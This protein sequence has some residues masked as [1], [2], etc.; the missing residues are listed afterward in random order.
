MRR[1]LRFA[2]NYQTL[3]DGP[4]T[5]RL[6]SGLRVISP[7][8]AEAMV[9]PM[10]RHQTCEAKQRRCSAHRSLPGS[11]R[12]LL[13]KLCGDMPQLVRP[14]RAGSGRTGWPSS[15][16]RDAHRHLSLTPHAARITTATALDAVREL[17]SLLSS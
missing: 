14:L 17:V 1:A 15:R 9:Q 11:E 2:S 12:L 16:N 13:S 3:V 7:L 5:V 10:T 4:S 8:R 6:C